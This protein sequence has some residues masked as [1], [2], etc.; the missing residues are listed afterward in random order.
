MIAMSS[1]SISCHSGFLVQISGFNKTYIVDII[2]KRDLMWYSCWKPLN[3][4][5]KFVYKSN[6]NKKIELK[7]I[8]KQIIN[9][10]ERF[11]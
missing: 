2:N 10:S 7:S 9:A 1:Y 8:F 3:T 6:F 11:K 4:K 5:H